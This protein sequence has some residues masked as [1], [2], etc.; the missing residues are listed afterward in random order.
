MGDKK[1]LPPAENKDDAHYAL[2]PSEEIKGSAGTLLRILSPF[3]KCTT[4]RDKTVLGL[5]HFGLHLGIN[6]NF[7]QSDL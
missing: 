7:L 3:Q 1:D 4:N 5:H 2:S 6:T